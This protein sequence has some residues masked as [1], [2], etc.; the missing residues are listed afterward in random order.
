M[1][2]ALVIAADIVLY[3]T[4][5]MALL[6]IV[7]GSVQA[8][9]EVVRGVFLR[10]PMERQRGAWLRYLRFLLVALT[11]QLAADLAHTTVARDWEG[12]VRLAVIAVIRVFLGYFLD[13]DLRALE[14]RTAS[15][16]LQERP[17]GV[18]RRG[19]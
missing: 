12:L 3:V 5:A 16:T 6:V 11:F 17:V 13:K 19:T 7:Y 14:Q 15:A 9:W 2:E 18:A 4:E 1:H 10:I 8:F